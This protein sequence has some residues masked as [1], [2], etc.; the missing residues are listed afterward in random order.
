M[1][2]WIVNNATFK[3]LKR[4]V[5]K[6]YAC[7][8]ILPSALNCIRQR[9]NLSM[10]HFYKLE[11]QALIHILAFILSFFIHVLKKDGPGNHS[12]VPLN[13]LTQYIFVQQAV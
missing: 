1:H 4:T 11:A 12:I 3:L 5:I 7:C 13:N 10:I 9:I 6:S 2:K 8:D